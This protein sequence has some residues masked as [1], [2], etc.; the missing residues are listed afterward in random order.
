MV[1]AELQ[2]DGVI[3]DAAI[4]I[5]DQHIF[6]L[7]HLAAGQVPAAQELG[8]FRRVRAGDLDLPFHR[9][10]AQDGLVH[11]VPEILHRIA[12][13]PRDIHVVIDREAL[14]PPPQRRIRIGRFA[15]LRAETEFLECLG[16]GCGH[17][18][19]SGPACGKI[20]HAKWD[21]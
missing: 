6:A 11:E 13:I 15:H 19:G 5:R 12:E 18:D 4:L 20:L 14:R 8:E 17:D 9:H 2:Q 3:D 1:L 7:P 10:I 21:A 16:L